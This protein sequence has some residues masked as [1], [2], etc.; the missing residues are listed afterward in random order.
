MQITYQA[1]IKKM[2]SELRKAKE[3]QDHESMRGHLFAVKALAELT[4]DTGEEVRKE[5]P[6]LVKINENID[7]PSKEP[8]SPT[9]KLQEVHNDD[10]SIFDF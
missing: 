2:E 6:V 8:S 9:E 3:A 7:W 4:L 1:L 10:D 5:K